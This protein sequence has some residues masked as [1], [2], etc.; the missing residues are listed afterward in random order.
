MSDFAASVRAWVEQAGAQGDLVF[1]G[2]VEDATARI[3][4]LTPV[5]TGR[6]R[7]SIAPDTPLDSLQLGDN[8]VISTN[9]EYARRVEYGFVGV[10]ALGR[11]YDQAGH[12][13]FAQTANELPE[14][15][16][17]VVRRVTS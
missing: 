2:I 12:H 11:R 4:Q 14:I 1:R 5:D 9:V 16:E 15:A 10:D 6:L 17:A 3:K 13:M 7:V 8:V